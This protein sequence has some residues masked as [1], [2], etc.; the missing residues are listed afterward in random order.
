MQQ[1]VK[2][3]SG[4]MVHLKTR[5]RGEFFANRRLRTMPGNLS[6]TTAEPCA[7]GYGIC[8]QNLSPSLLPQLFRKHC[9]ELVRRQPSRIIHEST[10][11][12]QA[13][14]GAPYCIGIYSDT[15]LSQSLTQPTSPR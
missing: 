4:A 6:W 10:S 9:A 13:F 2:I 12:Q 15:T 8:V 1:R 5:L 7:P 3:V 11:E 14:P